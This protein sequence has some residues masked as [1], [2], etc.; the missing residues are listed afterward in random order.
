M[1]K[2]TNQISKKSAEANKLLPEFRKIDEI[3]DNIELV[4]TKT[5]QTKYD[6]NCFSLPIK[7]IEKIHNY[8]ITLDEAIEKQAEL[9]I[10][11]NKLNKYSNPRS[12]KQVKE[13]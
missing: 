3:V 11:I 7:L 1:L 9:G 2:T 5:D 13:F 8:E 12:I 6:F 4:C 10:L